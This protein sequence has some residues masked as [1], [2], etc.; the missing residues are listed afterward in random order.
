MSPCLLVCHSAVDA[1][2]RL[3]NSP[4][5]SFGMGGGTWV[6]WTLLVSTYIIEGTWATF[7]HC[8][9]LLMSWRVAWWPLVPKAATHCCYIRK[10]WGK[11]GVVVCTHNCVSILSSGWWYTP[12]AGGVLLILLNIRQVRASSV[13]VIEPCWT[14]YGSFYCLQ[15]ILGSLVRHGRPVGGCLYFR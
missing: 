13:E 3:W 7:G 15:E 5:C 4:M 1:P 14:L 8:Q 10:T 2:L 11:F 9:S 12:A 6:Y